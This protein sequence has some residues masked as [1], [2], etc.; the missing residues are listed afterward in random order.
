MLVGVAVLVFKGSLSPSGARGVGSC[1]AVPEGSMA[2]G[3]C[4]VGNCVE[5]L[6]TARGVRRRCSATRERMLSMMMNWMEHT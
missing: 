5:Q 1:T 4:S 3:T 2:S 6:E